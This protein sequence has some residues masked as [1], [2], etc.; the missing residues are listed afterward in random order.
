MSLRLVTKSYSKDL[1]W[2]DLSIKSVLHFCAE[3]IE[4]HI[5][6]D[7]PDLYDLSQLVDNAVKKSYR[8]D[9]KFFHYGMNRDWPEAASMGGYYGQQFTKMHLHRRIEGVFWS[10][11]SDVIAQRPFTH[12]DLVGP[13]GKQI[14][15]FSQF[16][17]LMGG[18]DDAAHRA[19]QE[20]IKQVFHIPEAPHEWMRAMP[21]PMQSE[22]LRCGS[23]RQEW[24]DSINMMNNSNPGF[25]EFNIIGEFS[26]Q[27]FPDSYEWRNAEIAGP[28]WAGGYVQ[29][30]YGSGRHDGIS[31]F[32]QSW[33]YGGISDE[34]KNWVNSLKL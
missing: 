23:S 6:V 29:G 24:A 1:P 15:W 32:T 33:S 27:Y 5:I 14:M 22:I 16:N 19:R 11:D 34:M 13:T 10:I 18:A 20:V 3:P 30:G 7:D 4:W 31:I 12:K 21:I 9:V 28:T 2:L 17:S 26:H 8:E 25:S